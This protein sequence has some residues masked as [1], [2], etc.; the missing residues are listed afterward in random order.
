MIV[1]K[2]KH[3]LYLIDKN[4]KSPSFINLSTNFGDSIIN[5]NPKIKLQ[6]K[7]YGAIYDTLKYEVS[8]IWLYL[9]DCRLEF[10]FFWKSEISDW[11]KIESI[12]FD[13][14]NFIELNSRP[15]KGQTQHYALTIPQTVCIN[16]I[17]FKHYTFKLILTYF[18]GIDR[19]KYTLP[20]E[21]YRYGLKDEIHNDTHLQIDTQTLQFLFSKS[22]VRLKYINVPVDY[23]YNVGLTTIDD[24]YTFLFSQNFFDLKYLGYLS[25][26]IV[27]STFG[28][29]T[30]YLSYLALESSQQM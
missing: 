7:A 5:C 12:W 23:I 6:V 21:V 22:F 15:T 26:E 30:D 20:I 11:L 3:R 8:N 13:E 24:K 9:Y 27:N 4:P 2:F 18:N 25:D 28:I 10:D 29:Q 16:L 19:I 17:Y 1:G 14:F